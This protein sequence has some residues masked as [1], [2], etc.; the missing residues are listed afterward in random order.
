MIPGTISRWLCVTV[1]VVFFYNI[2]QIHSNAFIHSFI[3]AFEC[4]FLLQTCSW[5]GEEFALIGSTEWV[6][7]H[8]KILSDRAVVYLNFDSAV[9]GNFAM[10]S[11][12]SPLLFNDIWKH[13]NMVKDPNQHDSQESMYDIMLERKPKWTDGGNPK[14][15]T[16]GSGSDYAPFYQ[17]I[18]VPSADFTYGFAYNNTRI[19]YPVYHSQHDSFKWM[20][21]FIDPEFKFHK[22]MAQLAG[23]LVLD[24]ADAPLLSMKISP[25]ASLLQQSFDVL[26]ANGNLQG[27]GDISLDILDRAIQKFKAAA[28]QFDSARSVP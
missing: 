5:G 13:T 2:I 18:G 1:A 25:Y 11:S 6:E 21:K 12:S 8:A 24:Y 27:R 16:L 9:H 17:F 26:K 4:I 14:I 15:G 7:Q 22:A 28:D 20:V 10:G 3:Y 23:M 19:G